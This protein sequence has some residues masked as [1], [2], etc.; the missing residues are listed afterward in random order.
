MKSS[1]GGEMEGTG[2]GKGRVRVREDDRRGWDGGVREDRGGR[3]GER[4]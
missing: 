4:G 1:Y 3:T 2:C